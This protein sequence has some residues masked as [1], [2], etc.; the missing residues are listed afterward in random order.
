MK[1]TLKIEKEF[2]A[3]F[4]QVEAGVRYWEDTEVN[5]ELDTEEGD[6]VPC[7][8]GELWKPLIELETGRVL[9]WEVGKTASVHYKVC[10]KGRY[11]LQDAYHEPI[12][13]I[14]GY[15]ISDLAIGESGFGDYI[16]MEIDENGMIE[17][18]SPSL[19]E[20]IDEEN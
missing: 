1:I 11:I 18:W 6:N 4:L 3:K 20:F 7:K 14:D 13:T 15:V 19:E 2:D 9:N 5:G 12:K 8:D 10:D 16:I 17:N